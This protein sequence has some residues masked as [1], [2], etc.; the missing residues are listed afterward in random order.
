MCL[1]L[2]FREGERLYLVRSTKSTISCCQQLCKELSHLH[3]STFIMSTFIRWLVLKEISD[4]FS[5]TF[6][7]C[8][9]SREFFTPFALDTVASHGLQLHLLFKFPLHILL[10]SVSESYTHCV[11]HLVKLNSSSVF[12]LLRSHVIQFPLLSH[13]I[14]NLLSQIFITLQ[15]ISFTHSSIFPLNFSQSLSSSRILFLSIT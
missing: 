6:S 11:F 13:R 9:T 3:I 4:L 1:V 2:R 5:H 8:V 7:V 14:P 12:T 10:E 15:S